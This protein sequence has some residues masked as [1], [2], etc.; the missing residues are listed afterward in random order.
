M[1]LARPSSECGVSL[2]CNRALEED[3]FMAESHDSTGVPTP[4]ER[5]PDD[6]QQPGGVEATPPQTPPSSPSQP[7]QVLPAVQASE[8]FPPIP[9][10][11][12]I[13][14]P[15]APAPIPQSPQ[16]APQPVQYAAS[17]YPQGE[18]GGAT[19]PWTEA[20]PSPSTDRPQPPQPPQHQ[21][22][23]F[24]TQAGWHQPPLQ[25]PVSPPPGGYGQP[26]FQPPQPPYGAPGQYYPPGVPPQPP[27]KGK[28][29]LVAV[30]AVLLVALLSGVAAAV[31]ISRRAKESV[32][33]S[34]GTPT[35]A[36]DDASASKNLRIT[37]KRDDVR[38]YAF[39][40]NMNMTGSGTGA[41]ADDSM[42]MSMTLDMNANM[43]LQ[44]LARLPD[45]STRVEVTFS[46]LKMKISGPGFHQE[47]GPEVADEMKIQ[48]VVKP[49]GTYVLDTIGGEKV[50]KTLP[51]PGG[52]GSSPLDFLSPAPLLPE[53][54]VSVGDSW[55]KEF[56]MPIPGSAGLAESGS[57][58][59][60]STSTYERDQE[61]SW[62]RA[63][64]IRSKASMSG[65]FDSTIVER[66]SAGAAAS[67]AD[68]EASAELKGEL[69]Y[70]FW[71]VPEL[72]EA[73][74]VTIDSPSTIDVTSNVTGAG[75]PGESGTAKFKID[76]AGA[77]ER[78]S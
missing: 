11:E 36:P 21:V 55:T 5:P 74:K 10:S 8:S 45:G 77:M 26:G 50:G 71:F 24:E 41:F 78:T 35:A 9:P 23:G 34:S 44:V 75:L 58:K 63:M 25:P 76:L 39:Q 14:T 32:R 17:T 60:V 61:T 18:P 29:W 51:N 70:T 67:A 65:K 2:P 64:V 56:E 27:R 59:I 46:D 40:M 38:H 52:V 13:P 28:G 31:V 7:T 66:G 19:R 69:S 42:P 37:F 49:D 54:P 20:T 4:Y 43:K 57:I 22:A 6:S 15:G 30:V 16:G 3:V 73:T 68:V 47:L 33:P 62:G 1:S 12:S 72:G 48:F 53:H